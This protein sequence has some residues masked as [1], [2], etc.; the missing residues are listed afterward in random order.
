ME[1]AIK[2]KP[3]KTTKRFTQDFSDSYYR[4]LKG[5]YFYRILK[6]IIEIGNLKNRDVK[7]LDFGCGIGKLKELLPDK[8]I[9]FDIQPEFTEIDD[10][11]KA[12]FDVI[13]AN[14]VFYLV[15]EKE[16]RNFLAELYRINRGVELIVAVSKRR[17]IHR[18][19]KYFFRPDAWADTKLM[20]VEELRVLTEKMNVLKKVNVLSM[21][22][23]YLMKFKDANIFKEYKNNR[24]I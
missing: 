10:W 17:L 14:Q 6:K 4:G 9:C 24:G 11:R 20:P 22:D 5:I 16:L 21:A 3:K 8:V 2:H 7:V 12:K 19:L 15:T 18:I 1:S 23:V 13:V